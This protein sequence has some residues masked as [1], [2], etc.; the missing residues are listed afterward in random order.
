MR[1]EIPIVFFLNSKLFS[2]EKSEV[3][4]FAW[5]D[6]CATGEVRASSG[7]EAVTGRRQQAERGRG[8]VRPLDSGTGSTIDTK[9][10]R[11]GHDRQLRSPPPP[12]PSTAPL[13]APPPYIWRIGIRYWWRYRRT[14]II[15]WCASV[16]FC[17]HCVNAPPTKIELGQLVTVSSLCVHWLF[18]TCS[19]E[20]VQR[21]GLLH[22]TNVSF[23][24]AIMTYIN[25]NNIIFHPH[26]N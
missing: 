25:H 16:S 1:K 14:T 6:V 9:P 21:T 17:Y 13:Q 10:T 19:V 26:K 2:P 8:R 24:N 12:P 20:S 11:L 3:L 18:S 15:S 4:A 22:L 5:R 23:C 7:G